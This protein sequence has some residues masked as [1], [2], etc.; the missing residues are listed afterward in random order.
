MESVPVHN[1]RL[2]WA[3]TAD[4]AKMPARAAIVAFMF[5][6]MIGTEKLERYVDVD[7]SAGKQ[8]YRGRDGVDG[9]LETGDMLVAEERAL[10]CVDL[11]TGSQPALTIGG[12]CRGLLLNVPDGRKKL[13]FLRES[14]PL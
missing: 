12:H 9:F 13:T 5:E 7:E 11:S 3:F 4:A 2:T 6:R 1:W 14:W 10:D 8:R